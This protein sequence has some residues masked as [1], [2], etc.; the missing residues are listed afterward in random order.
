MTRIDCV[1][2]RANGIKPARYIGSFVERQGRDVLLA[3]D[4]EWNDVIR[5]DAGSAECFGR[6]RLRMA[7]EV[8]RR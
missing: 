4:E 5:L 8:R 7:E 6:Q 2:A 3:T 1:V